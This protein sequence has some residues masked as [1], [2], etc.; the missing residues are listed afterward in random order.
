MS[1]DSNSRGEIGCKLE[2]LTIVA[3]HVNMNVYQSASGVTE[4]IE[5]DKND[6]SIMH[7]IKCLA[8]IIT[9]CLSLFKQNF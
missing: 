2:G 4:R 8:K 1:S 7:V 6:S 9:L 3:N 5:I